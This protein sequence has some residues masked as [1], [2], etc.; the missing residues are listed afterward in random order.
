[1]WSSLNQTRYGYWSD[2]SA[3]GL[4]FLKLE[5]QADILNGCDSNCDGCYVP[6]K[7]KEYDL[8]LLFDSITKNSSFTPDEV[9]FGPTDIFSAKN[10][11]DLLADKYF[12]KIYEVSGIGFNTSLESEYDD[13][14]AKVVKLNEIYV[15][16]DREPD[17]DFKVIFPLKEFLNGNIDS[18]NEKVLLL[19]NHSVQFR[20]NY[21]SGIFDDIKYNDLVSIIKEKYNTPIIVTPS[22]FNNRNTNGQVDKMLGLFLFDLA[23]QRLNQETVD[24]HTMFNDSFSGYGCSNISFY[25]NSFYINPFIF[26]SIIQRTDKFKIPSD[27]LNYQTMTLNIKSTKGTSCEGCEQIIKCSERNIPMYMDSRGISGCILPKQYMRRSQ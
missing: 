25:N 19:K 4:D 11:N 27:N 9:I 24:L 23:S 26:D 22:F 1:M 12:K 21:Y 13:I 10:F 6:R 2:E 5:V 20:V 18:F 8:K 7:N 15:G 17:I 16:M 14:E 3:K